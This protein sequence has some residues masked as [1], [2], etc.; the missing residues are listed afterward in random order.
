MTFFF[1][2]TGMLN[3]FTYVLNFPSL[4]SVQSDIDLLDMAAGYFG[5]LGFSTLS[6]VTVSFAK[7]IA[8]WARTAAARSRQLQ[9]DADQIPMPTASNPIGMVQ[10]LF[11]VSRC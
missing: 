11:E 5:Y 6:H 3:L 7:E 9:A 2:F 8:Q 10:P 1:P 4:P